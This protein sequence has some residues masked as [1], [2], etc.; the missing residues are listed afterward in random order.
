MKIEVSLGEVIDKYSILELKQ[1]KISD[2]NKLIEINKEM[3]I[4]HDFLEYKT[5]YK[6]YY[7][8][9]IYIN[10][11]IW[12]TTDIIKSITIDNPQ[13]ASLSNKIFEFNQKRFRIKNW[14]NLITKSEIKEQKS[15][16]STHCKI[17]VNNEKTLYDKIAEINYLSL[18]YDMITFEPP[19]STI[20]QNIFSCPAFIHEQ[21]NCLPEPTLLYLENFNVQNKSIFDFHPLT[22]VSSGMFGDLIHALSIINEN[23]YETGR[24]GILYIAERVERFRNGLQNTYNDTYPIIKNQNYIEDYKIYKNEICDIDLDKWRKNPKFGKINLYNMYKNDYNIEW[25]KHT[26]LDVS[27]DEKWKDVVLINTTHYRFPINIDFNLLHRL[28]EGKLIFI[29]AN[30]AEYENFTKITSLDIPYYQCN[31]FSELCIPIKSCKLFVGSLSGPLTIAHA[32]NTN[33]IVGL[34]KNN[35]ECTLNNELNIIWGDKIKYSVEVE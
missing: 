4:L 1:K 28:Y 14:F 23:F 16:A 33:R 11:Q 8:L 6:F 9:L 31:N 5:N 24:K 35:I 18:E 22:Y 19:C 25:G 2:A 20:L 10:E 32:F 29:A 27:S 7:N 30:I 13:F 34:S 17:I 15:Y 21:I 3:D 26:W 12:D